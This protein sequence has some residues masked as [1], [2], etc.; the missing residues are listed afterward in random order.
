MRLALSTAWNSMNHAKAQR[1]IDEIKALGFDAVELG[2]SLTKEMVDDVKAIVKKGGIKITSIHNYCPIPDE[3]ELAEARPDCYSLSSK[4]ENERA[5]AVKYTKRTID[6]AESVEAGVVVLHCGLVEMV[7][8]TKALAKMHASG[9]KD[10]KEYRSVVSNMKDERE[11]KSEDYLKKAKDSLNELSGYAL[12]KKVKLAVENRIYFCEIPSCDEIG[13]LLNDTGANVYYWH[14]TG[15]AQVL[16][17]L[18]FAEH[19]SYLEKYSFRMIGMHIH[20]ILKTKDHMAPLKGELDFSLFKPYIK[21]D[22]VLVLEPHQP[23]TGEEIVRGARHLEKL[24]S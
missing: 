12:N 10:T 4:D 3:F 6:T 14:D 8:S 21:K 20:D 17:N 16:E 24:F 19:K 13:L 18:G 1:M 9:L 5:L 7:D 15:H 11:L 23:A 2:F 22:T